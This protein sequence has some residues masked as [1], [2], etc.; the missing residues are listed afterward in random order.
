M[1]GVNSG[2]PASLEAALSGWGFGDASGSARFGSPI[3]FLAA[4]G[5]MHQRDKNSGAPVV[6]FI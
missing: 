3:S 5:Q 6:L 2:S 4:P 1:R